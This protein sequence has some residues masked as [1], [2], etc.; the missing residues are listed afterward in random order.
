[1]VAHGACSNCSVGQKN[2]EFSVPRRISLSHPAALKSAI[3]SSRP[4]MRAA[5]EFSDPLDTLT[6]NCFSEVIDVG[7]PGS[8]LAERERRKDKE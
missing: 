5:A 2:K 1:M 4:G 7:I 3:P 8:S 6:R